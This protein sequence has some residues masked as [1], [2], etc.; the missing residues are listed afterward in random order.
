[1]VGFTP[2]RFQ[3]GA[4]GSDAVDE[5]GI[6]ACGEAEPSA[7]AFGLCEVRGGQHRQAVVGRGADVTAKG[8][9]LH[10]AAQAAQLALFDPHSL[11]QTHC[12]DSGTLLFGLGIGQQGILVVDVGVQVAQGAAEL[13]LVGPLGVDPGCRRRS[14]TPDPFALATWIGRWSALARRTRRAERGGQQHQRDQGGY[15]PH[16]RSFSQSKA[17]LIRRDHTVI[18]P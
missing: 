8:H 5:V 15:T 16:A 12:V 6:F 14:T 13:G 9:L 1:L 11:A 4:H 17:E 3:V 10:L 18:E 7:L 2:A